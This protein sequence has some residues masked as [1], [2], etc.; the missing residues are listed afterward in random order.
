MAKHIGETTEQ[1]P[2]SH[3]DQ[4]GFAHFQESMFVTAAFILVIGAIHLLK[5]FDVINTSEWGIYPREAWGVNG[6]VL[7]P[8]VH[9]SLKHLLSNATPLVVTLFI[10]HYFYRKVAIGSLIMIWMMTG[11]AVWLLANRAWHIGAS[12]VVYGLV[13]FI[14]WTGIFRK[15]QN[16][17]C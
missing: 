1:R 9:G 7:A 15:N 17:S 5:Q 2:G 3:A 16:P 4:E 8:L 6:I 14:F 12:G 13:S 10:L 11:F